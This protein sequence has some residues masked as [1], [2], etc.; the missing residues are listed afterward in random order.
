MQVL[1][2]MD[3]NGNASA[4]ASLAT[5]ATISTIVIKA[6]NGAITPKMRLH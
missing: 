3:G 5:L 2:L 1:E 4:W 6:W